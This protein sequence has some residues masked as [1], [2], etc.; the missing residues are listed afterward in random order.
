MVRADTTHPCTPDLIQ[1]SL[2]LPPFLHIAVSC[3]ILLLLFPRRKIRRTCDHHRRHTCVNLISFIHVISQFPGISIYQSV[4]LFMVNGIRPFLLLLRDLHRHI[5][6]V[7]V[8]F[9]RASGL[10]VKKAVHLFCPACHIFI[11]GI[12]GDRNPYIACLFHFFLSYRFFLLYFCH[13][14]SSFPADL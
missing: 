3:G 2:Y 8:F 1:D 10:V 11:D 12:I 13:L 7:P 14:M 5:H 9:C 6:T 4:Y